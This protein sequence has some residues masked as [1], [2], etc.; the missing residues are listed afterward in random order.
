MAEPY[1]YLITK[2]ARQDLDSLPPAVR[3]RVGRRLKFFIESG[4]PLRLATKLKDQR[5]GEYRFRA[6]AYR[7]I[8]DR[9]G[10]TLH[11]LRVQHRRDVYR[12]R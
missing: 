10:R 4:D 9:K 1:E 6:G 12:M 2:R 5:S 7:I 8:F 3:E 11:I